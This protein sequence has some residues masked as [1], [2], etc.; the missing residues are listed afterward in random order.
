VRVKI[1]TEVERTRQGEYLDDAFRIH[2]H[3]GQG[4]YEE[5][6]GSLAVLL[7]MDGKLLEG[8]NV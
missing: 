1:S 6:C 3:G 5:S 2:V 4:V 8:T 7:A